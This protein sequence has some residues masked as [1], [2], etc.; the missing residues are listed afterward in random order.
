M[1]TSDAVANAFGNWT[2]LCFGLNWSIKGIV[3]KNGKYLALHM[4]GARF[5]NGE[6]LLHSVPD[7]FVPSNTTRMLFFDL[8]NDTRNLGFINITNAINIYPANSDVSCYGDCLVK[9]A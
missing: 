5:T 6:E 2:E 9:I 8:Y 7:I 3:T 1:I 4:Q